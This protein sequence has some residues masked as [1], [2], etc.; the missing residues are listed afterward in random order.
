MLRDSVGPGSRAYF[1][2]ATVLLPKDVVAW[3]VVWKR[4]T[5]HDILGAV[6]SVQHRF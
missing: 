4:P 3:E 5:S 1:P 2:T 6:P